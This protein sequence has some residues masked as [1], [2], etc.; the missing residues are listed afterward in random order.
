MPG[1]MRAARRWANLRRVAGQPSPDQRAL[2]RRRRPLVTHLHFGGC[3]FSQR[4][5]CVPANRRKPGAPTNL[6]ARKDGLF[7]SLPLWGWPRLEIAFPQPLHSSHCLRAVRMRMFVAVQSSEYL[8]HASRGLPA[9][10]GG[11]IRAC[12]LVPACQP[13]HSKKSSKFE[14][15]RLR[16][17]LEEAS[18]AR[19]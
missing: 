19:A 15:L 16:M 7:R 1:R 14:L 6:D 8:H 5:L 3:A 2:E 12:K 18:S 9:T 11:V 17:G 13:L 10:T 4:R